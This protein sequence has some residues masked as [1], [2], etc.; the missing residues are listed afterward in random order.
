M[1]SK[2]ETWIYYKNIKREYVFPF[3]PYLLSIKNKSLKNSKHETEKLAH[4]FN[5]F[6]I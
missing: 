3:N 4:N 1:N 5:D 2:S 6:E